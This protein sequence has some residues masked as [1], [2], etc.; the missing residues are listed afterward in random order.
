MF[1]DFDQRLNKQV[2]Q[3]VDDRFKQYELLT[4]TKPKE[5]KVNVS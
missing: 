5:Q 4:G 1:K 2:Q 3:R